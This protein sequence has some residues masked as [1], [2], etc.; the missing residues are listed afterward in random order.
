MK[1]SNTLTQIELPALLALML[2]FLC[3]CSSNN[4]DAIAEGTRSIARPVKA[5]QLQSHNGYVTRIFP[6]TAK[7][8][9]DTELSFRVGGPLINLN[10]ETGRYFER[11]SSIARIDPRD[12]I[13][14]I[15]T[16][17]ARLDAS[18]AQLVESR[19]QYKRYE[20]LIKENAAAK[21]KYD[22]V[23]VIFE[24]AEAQVRTDLK[25]LEDAGNALKDAILHAPFSGY[26]DKEF[27][28]NYEIVAVGQPII[29]LMDLSAVEIEIA[30]PEDMLPN[31]DYFESYTCEFAALPSTAF[32]A[33]FKEI[34]KKPN[35][36]N[37]SYPL[38]LTIVQDGSAL[39]RP[40]MA[41]EVTINIATHDQDRFFSV[42]VAAVGN[43]SNRQSFTWIADP[44]TGSLTKKPV[45]IHGFSKGGKLDISGDIS[46]GQWMVV[47]GVNSLTEDRKIRLLTS[48]SQS[49]VGNEL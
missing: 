4:G 26:V 28:E 17:E 31:I 19:L 43:D 15:N 38:I 45:S 32:K 14:R 6:G 3:S 5:I 11:N 16:L 29:S 30:L 18:N 40:G 25:S 9:Q 12:F 33:R 21:A 36:S 2:I 37:R 39:I 41:A 7:A 46:A 24:M 23:K 13:V 22:Q 27:V 44:E 8:L 35:A 34:G 42:P 20:Q 1:C 49:N 10:A 47:A 48:Q